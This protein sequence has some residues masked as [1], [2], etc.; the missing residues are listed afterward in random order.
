M[1]DINFIRKYGLWNI[2]PTG[3]KVPAAK[4]TKSTNRASR[5]T[6]RAKASKKR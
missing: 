4:S 3:T 2:F 5:R 6:T 1:A